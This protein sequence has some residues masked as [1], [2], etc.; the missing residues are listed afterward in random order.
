M[1]NCAVPTVRCK[2]RVKRTILCVGSRAGAAR[3]LTS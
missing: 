1:R 3:Y 2:Q